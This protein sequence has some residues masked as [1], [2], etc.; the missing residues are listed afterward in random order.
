LEQT[1]V[2]T[3]NLIVIFSSSRS[4]TA[5]NENVYAH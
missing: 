1:F 2:I 3:C 5:K 4:L